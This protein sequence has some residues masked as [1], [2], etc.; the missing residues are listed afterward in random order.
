MAFDTNKPETWA[1]AQVY[2]PPAS[3]DV[4][5]FQGKLD[6]VAG[7]SETNLPVVRLVWAGD[8][9]RCYS[10]FYVTWKSDGMGLASELRAKY[11]YASMM[12]PHT[13][14]V[15]DIPPPRWILEEYEHPG[16]YM[17]SWEQARFQQG[18]EIRP[19]PPPNGYY[20]W[21]L[22]IAD[23]GEKKCCEEAEKNKVVC[24]GNYRD[25]DAVDIETIREAVFKR[26]Q[27]R[28][29]DTT[30]PLDDL[31]LDILGKETEERVAKHQAY[32]DSQVSEYVEEH[33]LEL[34]EAFGIPVPERLRKLYSI[35]KNIKGATILGS[36]K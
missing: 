19:A 8:R 32:M 24:W 3:F 17:A 22:T 28:F 26:E 27:D 2:S 1:D 5:G 12:I 4:A 13:T 18:R 23:H 35:P 21:L 9:K 29:I 25:P 15:I 14:D 36:Q 11:K 7:L 10:K 33:A 16:Q 20:S 30:K 6:A 31:T 34:I